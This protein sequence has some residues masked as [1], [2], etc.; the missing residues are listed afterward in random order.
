MLLKN[1]ELSTVCKITNNVGN[2]RYNHCV[3]WLGS[4]GCFHGFIKF[5]DV[6]FGIRALVKILRLY[7]E[8]YHLVSVRSIISR[9]APTSENN[10]DVYI[11][12]VELYLVD[13]GLNPD[14]IEYRSEAFFRMCQAISYYE[15]NFMLRRC[16]YDTTL[17]TYDL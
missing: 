7:I 1:K 4:C 10:T 2:I 15:T 17:K 12:F 13:L 5:R 14:F 9:Y 8:K 3:N 11:S 16:M 6:Y